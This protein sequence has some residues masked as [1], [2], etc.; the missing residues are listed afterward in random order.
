MIQAELET[1]RLRLTMFRGTDAPSLHRIR[2]TPA[3]RR[4]LPKKSPES[5][6]TTTA[7][8]GDMIA[9][10]LQGKAYNLAIRFKDDDALLGFIGL[11]RLDVER[12]WGELGYLI[13]R[14]YWAQGLMSEALDAVLAESDG[15]WPRLTIQALV[16]HENTASIR[17]LVGRGFEECGPPAPQHAAGFLNYERRPRRIESAG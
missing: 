15:R 2:N 5:L 11:W 9:T 10:H 3:V 17:L 4:H 12:Q 13:D 6:A 14:R 16:H 8:V 7:L 1:A